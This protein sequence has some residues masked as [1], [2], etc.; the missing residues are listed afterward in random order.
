MFKEIYRALWKSAFLISSTEKRLYWG[1]SKWQ[2]RTWDMREFI[3]AELTEVEDTLGGGPRWIIC[4][5]FGLLPIPLPLSLYQWQFQTSEI[6]SSGTGLLCNSCWFVYQCHSETQK[7]F[8]IQYQFSSVQSLS[9]VWL[10]ATPWIAAPPSQ[11]LITSQR[12]HLQMSSPWRLESQHVNQVGDTSVQITGAFICHVIFIHGFKIYPRPTRTPPQ[13]L[14]LLFFYLLPNLVSSLL[15]LF[16]NL[17]NW[18]LC[19]HHPNSLALWF[20]VGLGW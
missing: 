7:S 19:L 8:L 12:P 16:C 5:S 14:V 6:L 17:R 20:P 3:M 11:A 10:F 13:V 4:S 18:S 15:S 1:R 2:Y 9:C